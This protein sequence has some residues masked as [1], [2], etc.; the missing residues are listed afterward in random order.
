MD[1]ISAFV[2][3]AVAAILFIFILIY[4]LVKRYKR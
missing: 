3:V 1:G 2:L 4:S